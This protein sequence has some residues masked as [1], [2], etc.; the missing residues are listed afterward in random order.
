[1]APHVVQVLVSAAHE[2]SDAVEVWQRPRSLA[3]HGRRAQ[4]S[5]P[6]RPGGA[7]ELLLLLLFWLHVLRAPVPA[8]GHQLWERLP[9]A[10]VQWGSCKQEPAT[11]LHC[12]STLAAQ[13]KGTIA[14]GFVQSSGAAEGP[15]SWTSCKL[16][17]ALTGLADTS[18][19]LCWSASPY[20]PGWR[21]EVTSSCDLAQHAP[22]VCLGRSG[23]RSPPHCPLRALLTV[24]QHQAPC[25]RSWLR[26]AHC[27]RSRSLS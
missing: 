21:E 19:A 4:A 16:P 1:M 15:R 8:A 13:L 24:Q 18:L 11:H 23:Q 27:P 7:Y 2:G 22:A 12:G 10:A 17:R 6:A 20:A 3:L 5:L 14:A 9:S 26:H 25:F